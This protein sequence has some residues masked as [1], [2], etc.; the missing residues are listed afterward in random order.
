MDS[1]NDT[2]VQAERKRGQHLYY[3]LGSVHIRTSVISAK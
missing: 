3:S 1:K 2:T